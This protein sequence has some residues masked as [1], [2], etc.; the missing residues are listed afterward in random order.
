MKRIVFSLP[1]TKLNFILFFFL[2]KIIFI[3]I[4]FISEQRHRENP[5]WTIAKV[6]R[7]GQQLYTL[8]PVRHE[9]Q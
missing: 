6:N 1:F 7:K 3:T 8:H 4:T 5:A 2:K 9:C